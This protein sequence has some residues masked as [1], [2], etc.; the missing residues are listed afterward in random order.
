MY[1][2]SCGKQ[3][4]DNS[5]FCLHCG[6]SIAVPRDVA[7]TVRG[8]IEWE[9]KE[10]VWTPP[11]D[12]SDHWYLGKVSY[13]TVRLESW[14]KYR[15][16]ILAELQKSLDEGW[17]TVTEIGP[18]CWQMR[19]WE[20]P[21]SNRWGCGEWMLMILGL[22]PTMGLILIWLFQKETLVKAE[23]FHIQMRRQKVQ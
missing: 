9:Y 4:P 19:E 23:T 17:E 11:P 5:M 10:F 8:P 6:T 14:S 21:Q 7:S 16:M 12:R 18:D 22:V 13:A 15:P 1:C 3:I 2:P 20:E